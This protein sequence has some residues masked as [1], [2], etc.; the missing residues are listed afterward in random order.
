MKSIKILLILFTLTFPASA[1]E[2]TEYRVVVFY[3][4]GTQTV[5]ADWVLANVTERY[6]VNIFYSDTLQIPSSG[7]YTFKI[8]HK[9]FNI[10]IFI[11]FNGQEV[12]YKI[13]N[14]Y[15]FPLNI[16]LNIINTT[17]SIRCGD[18]CINATLDSN[19]IKANFS[20]PPHST[21]LLYIKPPALPFEV[22][23][24]Y[25][26]FNFTS[27]A[28]VNITAPVT[29]SVEKEYNGIWHAKFEVKNLYN[30]S[31]FARIKTW[32]EVDGER[33]NLS[34][35]FTAIE[36]YGEWN[37]S[38]SVESQSVPVFYIACK[39]VNITVWNV[40]INPAYPSNISNPGSKYIL[41]KAI[42]MNKIIPKPPTGGGNGGGGGSLPP[43]PTTPTPTPT[44]T[45][46]QPVKPTPP[47]KP[48][49]TS[50]P[51]TTPTPEQTSP[52]RTFPVKTPEVKETVTV[53]GVKINAVKLDKK[54]STAIATFFTI[55]LPLSTFLLSLIVSRPNVVDRG[56][57]RP[58]EIAT[59]GRTVYVPIKCN[60]GKILPGNVSF[61]VPDS[62]LARD[63]HEY[64]DIPLRSAEAIAIAIK[65]NGR[66]FLSDFKA[67]KVALRL[68][69][70]AVYIP[71]ML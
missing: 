14:D 50:T 3:P 25:L 39:A 35:N 71:E 54:T 20:I 6:G 4:N 23:K 11:D 33:Y 48:T 29:V 70:D 44:S 67:Y 69:L 40:T 49:Q 53:T 42:V 17:G 27:P 1:S 51:E 9:P 62:E 36:P 58:E 21:G 59:F 7:N 38:S 24:S 34:S 18:H 61:V 65:C 64:Y 46:T 30:G 26:T 22:G 19:D 32:Y 56:L 60:M 12:I 5:Y 13:K 47:S 63:I 57:F 41:G 45:P 8:P 10:S 43:T 66:V 15:N 28:R 2:L 37:T 55:T 31:I 52:T 16:N 68:G